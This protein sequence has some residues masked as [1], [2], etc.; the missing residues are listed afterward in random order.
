VAANSTRSRGGFRFSSKLERNIVR[1]AGAAVG[2]YELIQDGDHI[3]AAVS[4]GKDSLGMLSVLGLLARRAPVSFEVT[5]V[6]IDHG[7]SGELDTEWLEHHLRQQG[8]RYRMERVPVDQIVQEKLEP[9]T[10]PCSLCSRIRRGVL[11]TLAPRLGCNKIALGHHLDDLVET[12]LL[13]FFYTG[14]LRAMAPLLRSDDGRN[15][16][17][18]PLCYVPE[19]W[20]AAYSLERGFKTATCSS[21]ICKVTDSQRQ[22][23]KQ[24][25]EQLARKRPNVRFQMLRALRNVR[26]EHL[27]DREL[28][29]RGDR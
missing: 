14:Q 3:L 7:P 10:N 1:R 16:V 8:C 17:V 22:E 25:V 12:L 11:Y 4:G 13:N 19:S 28:L 21:T 6:T 23:V 15:T 26:P 9:G 20:L 18:R 2:D 5:A 27:L 24:L 29:R